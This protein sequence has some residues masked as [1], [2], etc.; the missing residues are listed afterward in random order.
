MFVFK[1]SVASPLL[2]TSAEFYLFSDTTFAGTSLASAGPP[3][4]PPATPPMV[5]MVL[6]VHLAA[7]RLACSV[8]PAPSWTADATYPRIGTFST[9]LVSLP[10]LLKKK[11]L[12][13]T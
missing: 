13:G 8:C 1:M 12:V 5:V 9:N 6:F 10:S 2:Y 7:A 4:K 3:N 11:L